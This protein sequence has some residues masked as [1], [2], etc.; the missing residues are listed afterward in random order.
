SEMRRLAEEEFVAFHR[1]GGMPAVAYLP[2]LASM[3]NPAMP[4]LLDGILTRLVAAFPESA[5]T[6]T[7]LR[8]NLD[9]R[10][11]VQKGA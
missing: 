7:V 10:A 11:R 3:N 1:G 2:R 6:L 9:W 4:E 8:S 5:T